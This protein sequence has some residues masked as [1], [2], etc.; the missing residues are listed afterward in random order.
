ML[1]NT[2]PFLV[3]FTAFFVLYRSLVL[4]DHARVWLI[5]IAS[6]LFY[7]A[8]D[9]RFVPLLFGVSMF[10]FY[11]ARAIERAD[12]KAR[13]KRLLILSMSLNLG[14]LSYFKYTNFFVASGA[15]LLDALGVH[16]TA[17]ALH[18]ALPIGISFY[19]FQ[20]MSYTIDVYR[21]EV[22]ARTRAVDFLA[23]VSFFPHLVAGPIVRASTL[24][25]QFEQPR[26]RR[27]RD[28]ERGFLFVAI[29]LCNKT[30]ADLLA[31]VADGYFERMSGATALEAWTGVLAFAGQ[32]YGDFAGYSGI[33][34]GVA[35][36]LGF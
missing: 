34:I 6:F 17:P 10:D 18:I 36:L 16:V 3:F 4:H 28:V 20:S 19:T 15:G 33:A 31:P 7:A 32:V 25:P 30:L 5:V 11:V 12:Q 22:R 27:W 1:F 21:K 35:A 9:V 14:V 2:L 29:G 24:L 23:A 13:R 26:P 8:W